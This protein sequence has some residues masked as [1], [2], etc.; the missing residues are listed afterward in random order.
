M[1]PLRYAAYDWPASA[2]KEPPLEEE[3]TYTNVEINVG[4]TAEDFNPKNR[5]YNYP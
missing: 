4:L 2:G 5:S 3:Y 1:I